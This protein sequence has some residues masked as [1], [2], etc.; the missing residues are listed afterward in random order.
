MSVLLKTVTPYFKAVEEVFWG[1]RRESVGNNDHEQ[2]AVVPG[3]T[4]TQ[5]SAPAK[6][7]SIFVAEG[8]VFPFISE[9]LIVHDLE[10]PEATAKEFPQLLVIIA[11]D[12]DITITLLEKTCFVFGAPTYAGP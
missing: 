1:T 7:N 2:D 9:M 6:E 11:L 8:I 5:E 10:A 4:A 12:V 3:G